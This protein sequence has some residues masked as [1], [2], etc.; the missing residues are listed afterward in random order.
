MSCAP[1][2]STCSIAIS[3][4]F[5]NGS[6]K[7]Q[8]KPQFSRRPF[9]EDCKY[10]AGLGFSCS[11]NKEKLG[12]QNTHKVGKG[13]AMEEKRVVCFEVDQKEEKSEK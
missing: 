10:E 3:I 7:C 8:Q 6:F 9:N 5:F 13:S 1:L 4:F 11:G 2:P 12:L